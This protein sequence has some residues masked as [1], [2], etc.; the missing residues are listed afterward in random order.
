MIPLFPRAC[1]LLMMYMLKNDGKRDC[2][3]TLV[4]KYNVI[5]NK[6]SENHLS[7]FC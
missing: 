7:V 6:T 1:S 3:Y 2:T 4:I 5:Q